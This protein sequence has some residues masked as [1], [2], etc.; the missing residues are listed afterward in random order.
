MMSEVAI[1]IMDDAGK[2][3]STMKLSDVKNQ[4]IE[5]NTTNLASGV[6]FFNIATEKGTRAEMFIVQK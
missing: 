2:V 4:T 6:Y 5:F 3:I 1:S